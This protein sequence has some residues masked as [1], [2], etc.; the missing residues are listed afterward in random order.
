[1]RTQQE[2][3]IFR[4]IGRAVALAR[5]TSP[6]DDTC[7]HH[8]PLQKWKRSFYDNRVHE[9]LRL[10][11]NI[12]FK[13][14]FRDSLHAILLQAASMESV[15]SRPILGRLN[16]AQSNGKCTPQIR[17]VPVV[18]SL[19]QDM[20]NEIT[21]GVEAGANQCPVHR[22]ILGAQLEI[23]RQRPLWFLAVTGNTV[24]S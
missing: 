13:V 10:V 8:C 7:W 2:R 15:G 11:G 24:E 20:S 18:D 14:N 17:I 16:L 6:R 22:K 21:I 3:R 19:L 1:M 5:V 23:A 9:K 12:E 4:V